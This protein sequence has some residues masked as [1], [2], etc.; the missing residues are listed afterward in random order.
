LAA[1]TTDLAAT[2]AEHL[3]HIRRAVPVRLVP[4][5][6]RWRLDQL[7][8]DPDFRLEQEDQ[9]R[10]LLEHT[11]RASEIPELG[12]RYAEQ[13]LLRAHLRWHWRTISHQEVRGVEWLTTRRDPNRAIVL[14]F[15]HHN[16]YDGLFGSLARAGA[17]CHALMARELMLPEAGT[18]YRQHARI[19]TRGAQVVPADSGTEAIVDVLRPGVTLAI[20]SDFPGRT[21]VTFLGRRVLGSFGAARIATMTNSPVVLVTARRDGAGSYVQVE[22]P[23]EPSDYAGPGEL[24]EDILR[25]HEE[26]VLAWPEALDGP[27]ARWGVLEE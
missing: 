13:M 6:V 17:R 26:P 11:E 4:A 10:Y 16:R 20:A 23:L 12:Y 15:M 21:P 25:R 7:W 5:L 9:M 18:V 3:H 24:L 1:S 27:K 22:P 8:A 2:P 14:S 19:V